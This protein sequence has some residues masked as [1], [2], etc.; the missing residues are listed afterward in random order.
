M[1]PPV[2]EVPDDRLARWRAAWPAALAAWSRFTRIRDARLCATSLEAAKEGL[3]GSFAMIRLV[4]KSVVIDLE[5]AAAIDLDDYAV[6]ILAHEIGHHVLAPASA[7]DS[8]RLIARLRAALP[9][10]ERHAPMV[11]NLYTDLL[12]NDRL[13]RQAGLRMADV[14]ARM[15]DRLRTAGP[16]VARGRVGLPITKRRTDGRSRLWTLYMGIYES[17]WGL[18]KGS[19]GGPRGDAATEGD[20]W[21]GA[22]LIRVY[23]GEWMSAAG[24]FATLLLPYLAKDAEDDAALRQWHDTRSAAEGAD[25]SGAQTV[26]QDEAAGAIHPANDPRVTGTMGER[27]GPDVEGDGPQAADAATAPTA[28][29][30]RE[31]FEYGEILRAAGIVLSD[32]QIANRYYRERA[33]PHLV[34]FPTRPAPAS[35]ELQLEGLEQWGIGDALDEVDWIGSVTRSPTVIPGLTT[36][37]RTY[38]ADPGQ[39]MKPEPIDLDIYVDSSGSM[40]DPRQRISYLTLAG[41]VI[42]LSAL[43]TGARV[44]ATLW[45]GKNQVLTTPGFVRD[46]NAILNILTGY[47]GG[48]TTFPIHRL[49]ETFATR[50]AR[51]RPAHI[52]MISDDG[53]STMFD[54][55]ERGDSGWDVAAMALSRGR[56]GGTM[57]LNLGAWAGTHPEWPPIAAIERARSEQGWGVHAIAAMEDLLGFARAFSRR[58]YA[59]APKERRA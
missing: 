14:Y 32:E 56:A 13:Q 37:R 30:A 19:I 2:T 24:R 43:R 27:G 46:E 10:L 38:G 55:D 5:E 42:A 41:T 44:Q 20:A 57:A 35:E 18:E 54:D 9:T 23:A 48:G 58:H 7:T 25:P 53:I 6:E 1:A 28:G 16:A 4:D 15:H 33:L 29:Q 22:R 3:T 36:V 8:F 12:I 26:E 11:A 34:R 49:R 40:P 21:L 47:F 50:D 59:D 51:S 17:L 39:P 45:S 31:P 52:L